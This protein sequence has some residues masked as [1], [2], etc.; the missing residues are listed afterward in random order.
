MQ[1][2][3]A[4]AVASDLRV[5]FNQSQQIVRARTTS[6]IVH[7]LVLLARHLQKSE[8]ADSQLRGL[9]TVDS[10][11][12]L[13]SSY[14]PAWS[15]RARLLSAIAI[16]TDTTGFDALRASRDAAVRAVQLDS[17]S[18]EAQSAVGQ[19]IFRYDWDWP[20]A[21]RHFRRAIAL[22]SSLA[23]AHSNYSRMLRSLGRFDEARAQYQAAAALDPSISPAL[24]QARIS[25]FAHDFER[26]LREFQLAT[27]NDSLAR[28]FVIW[29]GQTFLAL[30]RFAEAESLLNLPD[31]G[32]PTRPATRVVVYA[33]SGRMDLAR[34]LAD[35]LVRDPKVTPD[36]KAVALTAIG[37]RQRALDQIERAVATH[38]AFVVDFK[39][40]PLL[41]SLRSEPRFQ[42]IL[43]QLRFP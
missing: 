14:A 37:E 25:Y 34:R 17:L 7:D 36:R 16:F 32:E 24:T 8:G 9:A 41:D 21:E 4:K 33:R 15:L 20:R 38:S 29:T 39:V 11:I 10:A 1:E 3:I 30:G 22:N 26:S 2:E 40:D 23:I 6:P 18:A 27:A 13:D 19:E 5:R 43:K 42:A 12:A 31:R 28:A 35:S